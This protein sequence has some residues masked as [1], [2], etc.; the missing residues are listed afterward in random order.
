MPSKRTRLDAGLRDRIVT[1]QQRSNS[2]VADEDS[3]EPVEM[4]TTLVSSMPAAKIDIAAWER[5]KADQT[6]ARYDT[7]WEM[8]YRLDMDPEL[9][10]VP[11]TRRLVVN[12][13]YH[14]IVACF[15]IGRRA[16]IEVLTMASTKTEDA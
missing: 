6:A 16:G 8:N 11:K 3:G 1:I 10:D 15:E 9:V 5:F 2:D 13:R 14:D 12:G 4:W 7:K